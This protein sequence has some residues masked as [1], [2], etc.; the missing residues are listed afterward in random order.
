[1]RIEKSHFGDTPL[2]HPVTRFTLYNDHKISVGII[3]LGA[4][5]QAFIVPDRDGAF[6]DIILGYNSVEGYWHDTHY[7]GAVIGRYAN[8]IGRGRF[9]LNG[10]SYNLSRNHGAHHLHGGKIGFN[11]RLWNADPMEGEDRVSLTLKRVSEDG[12]EGYP[13]NLTVAVTYSLNNNNE[14]GIQYS[15]ETDRPTPVNLSSHGYFNLSGNHNTAIDPQIVWINADHFLPVDSEFIPTGEISPVTDTPF[16]FRKPTVI[17]KR[18]NGS[19]AQLTRVGGYDHNWVLNDHDGKIKLQAYAYDKHSGR[20]LEVHTSEPGLQ[21]YSGN[22]LHS[23]FHGKSGTAYRRRQGL[24]FETQHFPNSPNQPGF[25]STILRPGET[26]RSE[27]IY[28][29]KLKSGNKS[30]PSQQSTTA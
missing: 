5:V 4:T 10:I 23:L 8:R 24:C 21:F 15:A 7:M 19:D 3:N 27:T 2:G 29:F 1:M 20:L 13:G 9:T 12:E 25:P 18:I 16:D 30:Q 11:K 6:D 26:Y 22:S 14:L 17:G 28:R